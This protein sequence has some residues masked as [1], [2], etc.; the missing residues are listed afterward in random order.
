M[1]E[2]IYGKGNINTTDTLFTLDTL[3]EA[4]S[5]LG[6]HAEAIEIQ[7]NVCEIAA[8]ALGENHSRTLEFLES[9]AS[10]FTAA[11]ETERAAE[12]ENK[13]KRLR[14]PN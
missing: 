12:V 3:S 14:E 2:K 11:G 7:N 9:L 10:R 13:V 6:K 1:K 4:Y 5:G 8:Q